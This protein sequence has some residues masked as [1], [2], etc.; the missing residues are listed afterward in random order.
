VWHAGGADIAIY[1]GDPCRR[2]HTNQ[3]MRY[4]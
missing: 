4:P 3:C 1:V 2:I